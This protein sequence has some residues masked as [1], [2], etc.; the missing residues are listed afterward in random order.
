VTQDFAHDAASVIGTGRTIAKAL[1][2]EGA[3]QRDA[4][5]QT[6]SKDSRVF[7]S[8]ARDARDRALL[9]RQIKP[10]VSLQ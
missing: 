10:G 4:L 9:R 2:I 6:T 5:G 8:N 3:D 7:A 1:I